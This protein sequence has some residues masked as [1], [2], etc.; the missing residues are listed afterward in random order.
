MSEYKHPIIP[1]LE[2]TNHY[3]LRNQ[4]SFDKLKSI[5][6]CITPY[7]P[8]DYPVLINCMERL[9][10]GI[11]QELQELY[12]EQINKTK[13]EYEKGHH[14]KTFIRDINRFIP[15]SNDK[16]TYYNA[17]DFAEKIQN[18]Y[19]SSR[20]DIDYTLSNFN[21]LF[22]RYEKQTFRLYTGLNLLKTK[23]KEEIEDIDIDKW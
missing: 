21:T 14:F 5:Y 3:L 18:Q 15:I 12:P 6:D 20:Y 17:L 11:C 1:K 10:K 19:N 13:D 22:R 23:T 4:S 16:D 7:C 2:S 8:D 9:Y